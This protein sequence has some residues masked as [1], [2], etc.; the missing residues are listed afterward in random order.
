MSL[1]KKKDREKI[2]LNYDIE[3]LNRDK[4]KRKSNIENLPLHITKSGLKYYLKIKFRTISCEESSTNLNELIE[5]KNNWLTKE[6]NKYMDK[7]NNM[8]ED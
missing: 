1:D 3:I 6:I 2:I 5:I 8:T 7:I 4:N